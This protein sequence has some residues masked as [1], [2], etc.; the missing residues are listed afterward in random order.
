MYGTDRNWQCTALTVTGNVRH[1]MSVTGIVVLAMTVWSVLAMTV[2][3][4]LAMMAWSVFFCALQVKG[5]HAVT[6]DVPHVSQCS[7]LASL[8][9][10]KERKSGKSA[11]K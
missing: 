10:E 2:W 11:R 3:S 9:R 8:C 7:F 6:K 1:L 4:V 5:A